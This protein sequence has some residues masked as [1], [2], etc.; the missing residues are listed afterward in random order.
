MWIT[1]LAIAALV[2]LFFLGL[3]CA[4]L[5]YERRIYPTLSA[6]KIISKIPFI[7]LALPYFILWVVFSLFLILPAILFL[8]KKIGII[9]GIPV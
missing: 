7:L 3:A 2:V 4:S 5:I 1:I 8:S 6:H 9:F